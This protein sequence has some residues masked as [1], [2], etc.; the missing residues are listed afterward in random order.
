MLIDKD[1]FTFYQ[2]LSI[3]LDLPFLSLDRKWSEKWTF[4][5][6]YPFASYGQIGI[7]LVV[8][9]IHSIHMTFFFLTV[10]IIN[11]LVY[12]SQVLGHK[13]LTFNKDRTHNNTAILAW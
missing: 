3:F 6:F 9:L 7:A 8:S 11:Y 12:S 13:S 1:T 10:N 2:H 4:I 5:I